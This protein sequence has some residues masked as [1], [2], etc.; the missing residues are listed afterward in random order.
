MGSNASVYEE[1]SAPRFFSI[2]RVMHGI[3]RI[4]EYSY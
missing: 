1:F 3:K 4:V 2:L